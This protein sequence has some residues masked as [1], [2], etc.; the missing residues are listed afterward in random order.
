MKGVPDDSGMQAILTDIQSNIATAVDE[1]LFYTSVPLEGRMS[2]I[3]T[4]ET[5]LGN[6]VADAVRAYYNTDI[7]FMNSGSLRCDR[8]VEAGVVTVKD[9][10]GG[11]HSPARRPCRWLT[12]NAPC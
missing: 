2:V 4:E 3:R 11:F 7:A 6:M 8:I 10:I 9:V 12:C 1:P 5:N